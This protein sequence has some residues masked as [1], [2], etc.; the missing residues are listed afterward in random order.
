MCTI[1]PNFVDSAIYSP[2]QT[3]L[4]ETVKM[5]RATKL[6]AEYEMF[7]T[8]ISHSTEHIV[9]SFSAPFRPSTRHHSWSKALI[10]EWSKPS[11]SLN[12]HI[13]ITRLENGLHGAKKKKKISNQT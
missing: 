9:S 4:R 7:C 3:Q 12:E 2:E 8:S 1:L 10:F 11:N 13:N 5:S 6:N